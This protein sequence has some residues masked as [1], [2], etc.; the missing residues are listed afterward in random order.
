MLHPN[1]EL[2]VMDLNSIP[3]QTQYNDMFGIV[4]DPL[5]SHLPYPNIG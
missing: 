1:K 5:L 2:G 4:E 3:T